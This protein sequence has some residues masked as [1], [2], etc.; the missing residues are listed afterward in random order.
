MSEQPPRVELD[1]RGLNCPMPLLKLKQQLNRMSGGQ[2]IC[3]L[4]TDPGSVGDFTA[5]VGLAGH[6]IHEQSE[7]NG[8]Y[9]FIIEKRA[10]S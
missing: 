10:D 1:A 2:Q 9:L 7:Q 3:V 4:T 5:F 8:E 6:K